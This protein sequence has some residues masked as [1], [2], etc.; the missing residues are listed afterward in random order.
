MAQDQ[1]E[2]LNIVFIHRGGQSMASYRY[3]A[4]IPA[5]E[6]GASVNEGQADVLIFSKPMAGDLELAQQAKRDGTAVVVDF[7]D[8]H[9]ATNDLYGEMAKLADRITCS[10]T[11][12]HSQLKDIGFNSKVIDDPYEFDIERPHA[13]GDQYLWFGHQSNLPEIIPFVKRGF[14][15]N[16]VTGRNTALTG[17]TEWSEN[18][19]KE[20]LAKSNIVIIPDGKST[21]SNNRMVN[22]LAAGCFVI[23]GKQHAEWR[24]MIFAGSI[25]HGLQF[26]A[27]FKNELND[28]VKEAQSYVID[29]HSPKVIAEQWRAICGSI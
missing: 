11:E 14:P 5:K 9:F 18:S 19:L 27:C 2:D 10:S 7:C 22:A 28:M 24:K 23:A 3:R 16:V 6:L 17:Y 13:N 4:A 25:Y 8:N 1:G 21:R 15:I 29:R 20:Q 26:A 12:L